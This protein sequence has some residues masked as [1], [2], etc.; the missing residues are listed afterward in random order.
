MKKT[1]ILLVLCSFSIVAQESKY[2]DIGYVF[3]QY[4]SD[5]DLE[6][7]VLDLMS[8]YDIDLTFSKIK[9]NENNKIIAIK[10]Y[11]ND[12]KGHKSKIKQVR[13]IPIRPIFFRVNLAKNG[14]DG[15]GFYDNSEMITKPK[16]IEIEKKLEI[17]E[18]IP[19]DA[20]I[21]VGNKKYTK[22]DLEYLDIQ[23]L[24]KIDILTDEKSLTKY[25]VKNKKTVYVISTNW[26][27]N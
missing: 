8:Q 27:L 4:S 11:F 7:V 5:K 16:N 17:I 23:N 10:V 12:N 25:N 9:R 20:E 24:G 6:N 13:E 19:Y 1:I 21:Y 3:D 14:V 26:T 22:E 2:Q 15:I 18:S